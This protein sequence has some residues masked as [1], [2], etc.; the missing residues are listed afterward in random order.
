MAGLF[1]QETEIRFFVCDRTLPVAWIDI[2][3]PGIRPS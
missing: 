3:I 2:L 1:D